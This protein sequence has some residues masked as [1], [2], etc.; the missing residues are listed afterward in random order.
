MAVDAD[1]SGRGLGFVLTWL[2]RLAVPALLVFVVFFWSVQFREQ[3]AP[4]VR[5]KVRFWHMW[6]AEWKDVVDRIVDRFN[7]SQSE[8]EVEA[9]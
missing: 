1:R 2:S 7:K 4:T 8:Y 9:L 5:K 6:T 3:H